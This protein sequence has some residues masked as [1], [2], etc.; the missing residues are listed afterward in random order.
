[1]DSLLSFPVG[2]FHSLQHAG[3]TR[4]SLTNAL[5]GN[6]GLAGNMVGLRLSLRSTEDNAVLFTPLHCDLSKFGLP[7]PI[8]SVPQ[9]VFGK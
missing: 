6:L 2:L 7:E 8:P 1:M 4:R 3:L 9:V 5:T